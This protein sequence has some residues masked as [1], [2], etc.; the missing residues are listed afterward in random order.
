MRSLGVTLILLVV[1][2]S[3]LTAAPLDP[4]D[5]TE[6]THDSSSQLQSPLQHTP[7]EFGM[8]GG[9]SLYPTQ[10]VSKMPNVTLG[11][12]SV[13]Y[14]RLLA[15]NPHRS[16]EYTF[17][18]IPFATLA[19]PDVPV[20]P[21]KVAQSD[22]IR[23]D[24][25]ITGIGVAP[26]GFQFNFRW[27]EHLHPF[28]GNSVGV[29]YFPDPVPDSRGKRLNFT[30]DIGLGLRVI[31]DSNMALTLGYRAHHLSNGYRGDI[32]PGF[33]SGIFYIGISMFR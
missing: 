32:N 12:L 29:M 2:S 16:I 3:V 20:P 1:T 27:S 19:Y 9:G 17:D 4:P 7:N 14:A 10:F 28:I 8:W 33:D 31:T 6:G 5:S 24:P 26:L 15:A 30:V 23:T 22:F 11:L 13:R 18:L 25:P 21:A